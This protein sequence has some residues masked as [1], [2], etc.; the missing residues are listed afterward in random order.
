MGAERFRNQL[1]NFGVD[2]ELEL[3]QKIIDTYRT[4]YSKIK[5]LWKTVSI[6]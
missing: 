6:V 2:I 1:R 5:Q 3:A 4:K